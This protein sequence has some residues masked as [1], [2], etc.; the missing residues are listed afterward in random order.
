MLAIVGSLHVLHQKH[1]LDH[2]V[3]WIGSSAGAL[4]CLTAV[5]GYSPASIFRLMMHIDYEKLNDANCDSML[6]FYDTMGV[7]EGKHFVRVVE[8]ILLKKGFH[9][10]ITFCELSARTNKE[11]VVAG[12]N[13]T[14]G[15]TESF[16][17]QRTPHMSVLLA[18][19]ISISVPFLFRPVEYNGNMYID[20]CTI[21]HVPVRFSRCP[22]QAMIIQ[23]VKHRPDSPET[24]S[25]PLP[26]DIPS[27][28]SL[29]QRRISHQLHKKCMKRAMKLKSCAIVSIC[30]PNTE[31][32]SFVVDFHLSANGKQ[33][34][35]LLGT[36]AT[37][38][39]LM[40]E[41]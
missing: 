35:F 25:A 15:R 40:K 10:Q 29:F 8:L 36:E 22:Q 31:N 34:L 26:T 7:L 30:I 21:E 41:K 37:Q 12:Y 11:L 14:R 6:S 20:G 27:F 39:Y 16:D 9:K 28:F 5:L 19:R 32:M 38:K 1:K 2:V 3:R 4:L 13:L 23:C 18:C 33:K 17:A 24:L